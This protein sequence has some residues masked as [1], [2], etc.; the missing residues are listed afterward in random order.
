MEAIRRTPN[1][2][3]VS[4]LSLLVLFL[5][6]ALPSVAS[7]AVGT[8]E[9]SVS[10]DTGVMV[11]EGTP[12]ALSSIYA[13]PDLGGP[14]N[15]GS[16][17]SAEIDLAE[18]CGGTGDLFVEPYDTAVTV[19][20][21]TPTTISCTSTVP[22]PEVLASNE[23]TVSEQITVPVTPTSVS[24]VSTTTVVVPAIVHAG[25]GGT[26]GTGAA[27]WLLLGFAATMAVG[28]AVSTIL[29]RGTSRT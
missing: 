9:L 18:G 28:L 25:G 4:I 2:R 5:V 16:A 17:M 22:D 6:F 13:G 15:V 3:R 1:A 20:E 24:V 14:E 23:T 21:G 26:A 29:T 27:V 11:P 7:A 19:P 8:S 12:K 10:P